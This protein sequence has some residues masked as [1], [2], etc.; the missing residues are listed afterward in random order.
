MYSSFVFHEKMYEGFRLYEASRAYVKR[1]KYN[2]Y[3]AVD[4]ISIMNCISPFINLR[5]TQA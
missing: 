4:I 2:N 5:Y 1:K 3:Y